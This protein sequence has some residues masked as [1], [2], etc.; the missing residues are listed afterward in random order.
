MGGGGGE[1]G[2]YRISLVDSREFYRPS[3]YRTSSTDLH[4]RPMCNCVSGHELQ[5]YL[6]KVCIFVPI[7]FVEVFLGICML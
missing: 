6:S 7:Q 3:H 1:G 5:I 4:G 2:D